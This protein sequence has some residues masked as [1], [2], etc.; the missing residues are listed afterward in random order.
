[1]HGNLNRRTPTCSSP[2]GDEIFALN[3]AANYA[4]VETAATG[5]VVSASGLDVAFIACAR[6]P[7]EGT[8]FTIEEWSA[9]ADGAGLFV[10]NADFLAIWIE[11]ARQSS[12]FVVVSIHAG[13]EYVNTP[14][15]TQR[16]LANAALAA[17]ADVVLG[18]HAHV[19]QPVEQRGNQLI[20]W[21]LGNF[22]FDL[23]QWD[24]AGIPEPRVS[25]ILNITL[26]KGVGVT[27]WEAVPVTLDAEADRPR[28]ATPDEAAVLQQLVQP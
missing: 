3:P 9:E 2:P 26:T 7:V 13:D 25:L 28:P 18:H 23:D 6:S 1:M 19:V 8:G 5:A 17:G 15:A 20:A 27:A 10:C 4:S 11:Q 21:G 14:N 16:E 12:D 22:I 24:L